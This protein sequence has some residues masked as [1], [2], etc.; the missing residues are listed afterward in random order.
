MLILNRT[1]AFEP[2]LRIGGYASAFTMLFQDDCGGLE[3]EHPRHPGHY[4][5]AK[6]IPDALLLNIGDMLERWTNGTS[7]TSFSLSPPLPYPFHPQHPSLESLHTKKSHNDRHIPLSNPPRRPPSPRGPLPRRGAHH[8]RAVFDPL[9]RR[10]G[11]DDARRVPGCL[12][13]GRQSGS[14]SARGLQRVWRH[15]GEALVFAGWGEG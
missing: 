13:G 2:M 1:P 5:P 12:Y 14:V 7:Y 10:A 11:R 4:M 3:L 8:A 9:L 6:P 15:E